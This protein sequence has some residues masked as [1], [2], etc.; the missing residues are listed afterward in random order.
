MSRPPLNLSYTCDEFLGELRTLLADEME[1]REIALEKFISRGSL[2]DIWSKQRLEIFIDLLAPGF[3]K[4][5][6][7]DVQRHYVQTLSILVWIRWNDWS[8]FG[9]IFFK[10]DRADCNIPA[11]TWNDLSDPGFLGRDGVHE[12]FDARCLF[13]PIDIVEGENIVCSEEWRLP[14]LQSSGVI[15]SGGFGEVAQETIARGHFHP[16]SLRANGEP[17]HVST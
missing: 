15:R 7:L 5:S 14:F 12:F 6:I 4:E 2:Q 3:G 9:T 11:Y 16:R 17:S 13:C 1:K 8:S 10:Q